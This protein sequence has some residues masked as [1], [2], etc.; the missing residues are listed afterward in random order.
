M[1]GELRKSCAAKEGH[2]V[3]TFHKAELCFRVC[4]ET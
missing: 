2:I 3:R 1:Q 4:L